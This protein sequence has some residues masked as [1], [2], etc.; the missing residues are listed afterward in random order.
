VDF[1]KQSDFPTPTYQA[2]HLKN[3]AM[4]FPSMAWGKSEDETLIHNDIIIHL[5][6][7]YD[8]WIN[9]LER[10]EENYEQWKT[11]VRQ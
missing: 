2:L 9:Y 1:P 7:A 5:M 8:N 3:L 6:N 4:P 11:R 10:K